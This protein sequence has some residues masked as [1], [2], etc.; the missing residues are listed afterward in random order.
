MLAVLSRDGLETRWPPGNSIWGGNHFGCLGGGLQFLC[1]ALC[2][3][4]SLVKCMGDFGY[5][6]LWGVFMFLV[7]MHGRGTWKWDDYA[8]VQFWIRQSSVCQGSLSAGKVLLMRI[9]KMQPLFLFLFLFRYRPFAPACWQA[10]DYCRLINYK[11]KVIDKSLLSPFFLDWGLGR[12]MEM[13]FLP[14]WIMADERSGREKMGR[15]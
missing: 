2:H 14:L 5:P 13:N 6:Q 15:F 9:G 4:R 7:M 12:W 8:A 3:L 11:N 1:S 10:R